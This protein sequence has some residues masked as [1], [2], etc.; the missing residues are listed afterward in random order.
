MRAEKVDKTD[1]SLEGERLGETPV[2]NHPILGITF[3]CLPSWRLAAGF[4]S[5]IYWAR[6]LHIVLTVRTDKEIVRQEDP[7]T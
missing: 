3:Y 2:D 1:R 5:V 4:R 6:D 7:P